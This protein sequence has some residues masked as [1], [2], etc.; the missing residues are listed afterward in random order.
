MKFNSVKPIILASASPRRKEL[1]QLLGMPFAVVP[2][3]VS[4]EMEVENGDFE[5]YAENLAFRKATGGCY[6]I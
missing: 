3:D 1:L 6:A 2:S 4:E 5:A